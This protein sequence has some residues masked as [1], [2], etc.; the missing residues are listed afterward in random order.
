LE[1]LRLWLVFA[2]NHVE[3]AKHT[4]SLTAD[5]RFDFLA[6][7]ILRTRRVGEKLAKLIEKPSRRGGMAI[8]KRK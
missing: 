3:V 1:V 2:L 7:A 6:D 8:L 5:D 4:L